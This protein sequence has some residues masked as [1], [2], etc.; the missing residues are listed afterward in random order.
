MF[1]NFPLHPSLQKV[2]GV[3]LSPYGLELKALAEEIGS[4]WLPRRLA[5]TRTPMGLTSSPY[6]G[7]QGMLVAEEITLGDP[8]DSDNVFR[9]SSLRQNYPGSGDYDP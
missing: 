3:D 9:W 1:L 5:W 6:A 4:P 8:D 7:V 2:C